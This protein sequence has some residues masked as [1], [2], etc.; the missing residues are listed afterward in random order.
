MLE[1][2]GSFVLGVLSSWI[3]LV[4]V[5]FFAIFSERA[6]KV[7]WSFILSILTVLSLY[8]IVGTT[9]LSGISWWALLLMYTVGGGVHAMWRWFRSTAIITER[10]NKVAKDNGGELNYW[11]LG[12]YRE[13]TDYRENMDKITYW[14]MAWPISG[15]A[16]LLGDTVVTVQKAIQK[17]FSGILDSI[18]D[19]ARSKATF[20]VSELDD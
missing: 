3:F 19:R 5:F 20:K 12:A 17:F 14:V 7:V 11:D 6:E 4:V 13:K 16:H 8:I 9:A 1:W 10:Y 15:A 18:A 2:F